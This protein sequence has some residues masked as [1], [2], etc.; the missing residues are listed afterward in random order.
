MSWLKSVWKWIVASGALI[1]GFVLMRSNEQKW[2]EK[3]VNNEE[4]DIQN[5]L[6]LAERA[7]EQAKVHDDKAHEIKAEAEKPKGKESTSTLLDRWRK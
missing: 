4:D 6:S 7:N 3:A 1:L 5:D 2:Q